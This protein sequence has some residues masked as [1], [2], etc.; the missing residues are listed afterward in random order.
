MNT[1]TQDEEDPD[2]TLFVG[3]LTKDV[4]T[5]IKRD[6]CFATLEVQ[7]AII[8]FN[9]DTGSQANIMPAN[10]LEQLKPRSQHPPG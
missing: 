1:V 10:K 2:D 5:E 3:A 9:V 6:E 4:T 7:G 8:K